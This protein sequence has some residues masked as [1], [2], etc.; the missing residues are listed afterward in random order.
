[1]LIVTGVLIGLV[2]AIMT[3]TTI[4]TLQGLG[5]APTT[6]TGFDIGLGWGRW[7]GLYPT[8]EGIGGQLAAIVVVYGS[9]AAARGLQRRRRKRWPT[10]DSRGR[11]P[12]QPEP[13]AGPGRV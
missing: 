11:A 5:W 4:H 7:L 8:W 13:H 3:G 6:T 9:Y 1:M 10:P 2:R 12:L